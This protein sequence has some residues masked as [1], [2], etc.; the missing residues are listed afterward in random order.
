MSPDPGYRSQALRPGGSAPWPG[1]KGLSPVSTE[2]PAPLD[3][4][5]G[6]RTGDIVFQTPGLRGDRVRERSFRATFWLSWAAIGV[7]CLLIWA[8]AISLVF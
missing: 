4:G 8:T 1:G 2:G 6:I 5:A 7:G 3:A